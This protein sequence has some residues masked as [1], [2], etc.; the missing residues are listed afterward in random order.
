LAL[1]SPIVAILAMGWIQRA[2][3]I[4]LIAGGG[5]S[6][7][8]GYR[9]LSGSGRWS[10]ASASSSVQDR[11]SRFTEAW[12]E[13]D[14]D[15]MARFV[16]PADRKKFEEWLTAR[17]IA[18]KVFDFSAAER[19]VKVVK[20]AQNEP[21]GLVLTLKLTCRPSEG[22]SWEVTQSQ[23]WIPSA[24]NWYFA[25]ESPSSTAAVPQVAPAPAGNFEARDDDD[26]S[27]PPRPRASPAQY[28]SRNVVIPSTVPPWQR[29]R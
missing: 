6:V 22:P 28:G 12:A 2:R 7:L 23:L 29:T 10:N 21:E 13:R 8:F 19:T 1:T 15:Q 9:A 25:A 17:P 5:W 26:P 3:W 27:P 16:L 14:L 4:L 24:G 18:A 20:A 11:A